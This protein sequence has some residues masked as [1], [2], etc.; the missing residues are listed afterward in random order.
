VN[1]AIR[2]ILLVEDNPGDLRLIEEALH[3]HGIDCRLLHFRTA[4]EAICAL[5]NCGDDG[6]S[7]P[8]LILLDYNVPGGDARDI[9]AAASRNPSLSSIP[10]AVVTSSVAPGDREQ[11][12][13]LGAQCFI[14]KPCDLDRFL[15]EVGGKIAGLLQSGGAPE[16]K[17]PDDISGRRHLC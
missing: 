11:A 9:L 17:S 4:S 16:N 6:A 14:H 15:A 5:E 7:V 8:D 3:V 12:L 13:Q 1:P 2:S 10:K